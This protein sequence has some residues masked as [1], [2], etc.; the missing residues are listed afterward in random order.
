MTYADLQSLMAANIENFSDGKKPTFEHWQMF[1]L[2]YSAALAPPLDTDYAN[3]RLNAAGIKKGAIISAEVLVELFTNLYL[4]SY[5]VDT[6]YDFLSNNGFV[7]GDKPNGVQFQT[8]NSLAF[9]HASQNQIKV[10]IAIN[11]ISGYNANSSAGIDFKTYNDSYMICNPSQ[12]GNYLSNRIGST[13]S[14]AYIDIPNTIPIILSPYIGIQLFGC[15]FTNANMNITLYD[16]NIGT[17]IGSMP[18]IRQ[19]STFVYI[20]RS[21]MLMLSQSISNKLTILITS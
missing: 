15:T 20:S 6:I 17:T 2:A 19:S 21:D 8:L 5:H 10:S 9:L 14:T 1:A 16:D 11:C 18:T 12:Q 4:Q 3:S 13:V 7:N